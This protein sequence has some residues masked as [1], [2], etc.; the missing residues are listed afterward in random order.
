M[1]S[2]VCEHLMQ[3]VVDRARAE[4]QLGGDLSVGQALRDEASDL[5]FLR[6]QLVKRGWVALACSLARR[7]K[8][9]LGTLRE[10]RGA[11]AAEHLER[12][13]QV[14]TGVL[15][16]TLA[17]E[18]LPVRELGSCALKWGQRLAALDRFVEGFAFGACSKD[19]LA[20]REQC[21]LCLARR[22]RQ[23]IARMRQA[24]RRA[25]LILHSAP[26]PRQRRGPPAERLEGSHRAAADR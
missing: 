21:A 15:T 3:V 13:S 7:A 2:R 24:G 26:P 4:E 25:R 5:E 10:R 18:P 6:R 17:S 23:P 8:L 19:R 20:T 12:S 22:R 1:R 14:H 16:A 9:G 11:E